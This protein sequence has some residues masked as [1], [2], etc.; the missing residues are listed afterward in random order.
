MGKGRKGGRLHG[1]SEKALDGFQSRSWHER[2][3]SP[4]AAVLGTLMNEAWLPH[5]SPSN[6]TSVSICGSWPGHLL[7]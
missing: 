6:S 3:Q 5:P 7:I 2:C 1:Q 4:K